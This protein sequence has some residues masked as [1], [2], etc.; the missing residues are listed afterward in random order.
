[1]PGPSCQVLVDSRVLPGESDATPGGLGMLDD[2]ETVD[3]AVSY[4]RFEHGRERPYDRRLPGI[5]D[6][7]QPENR[8]GGNLEADA[9]DRM[10]TSE[11]FAETVGHDGCARYSH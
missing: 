10:D 1:M 2:I 6:A 5:V 11:G 4:V 7:E 3:D 8:A 9:V